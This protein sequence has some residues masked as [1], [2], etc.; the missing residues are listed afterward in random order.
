ME[1][2]LYQAQ[3]YLEE[4]GEKG[5]LCYS[6]LQ[7]EDSSRSRLYGLKVSLWREGTLLEAGEASVLTYSRELALCL[8]ER[9]HRC[10]I[11][12]MCLEE[13]VDD[14]LAEC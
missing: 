14:F 4:T 12:P 1:Q 9:L 7:Q 2:I 10:R 13:V 8:L 6:L 5:T 11:T 3:L